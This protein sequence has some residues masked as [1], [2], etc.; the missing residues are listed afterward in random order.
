M[1]HRGRLNV[2]VNVLGKSPSV[3]F[4][5]FEGKYDTA[6]MQGSGD[7]KYHKGFSSD[8]RT[9]GGNVH[10]A[11]A[12][13]PS[14]LEVVNPVVEGS[15][16]ARQERRGDATGTRVLPILIHGDAAFAGQGVVMETLQLSQ[17]R[18][19]FTGGSIHIIVNNQVG[20][21]TSDPRDARS[22]MYCSDVAKMLETP[23]FHVNARRSGSGGVRHAARA[24]VSPAF[25][26]GRG[27]RSRLL[28]PPWPQRGG[29]AIGHAADDVPGHPQASDHAQDLRRQARRAGRDHRRR[30]RGDDRVV[31]PGS[32]RGPPAGAR[33]ARHDRQQVHG[34]LEQVPR[35]RLDRAREGRR[36]HGAAQGARCAHREFPGEFRAASARRAGHGQSREDARRRIAARLGLRRDAGVRQHSRRRQLHPLHGPG[37]RSRHVLPSPRGAARSGHGQALRPAAAHRRAPAVVPDHRLGAV[38]RSRARFRIRLLDHRSVGA[39]HL[40]RS[41]RRLRER[42]AGHHRPVHQLG[43]SEVGPPLRTHA[44]PAARLRRPGP[45]AFLRAP[46]A[47]PATLRREQHAGVRAFDARADVSHDPPADPAL[48]C[49]SRSS[50]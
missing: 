26:Q 49:A 46:R 25:P 36:R 40:G 23:I 11:L 32:R 33:L 18:A 30:C 8:L 28:S 13:N 27:H 24:R 22:T 43:R 1:A 3:L 47:L 37:R 45:G 7:V 44:V 15:V 29:R 14:H 9:P 6:H 19:F 41:V 20:F 35:Q 16:R 4:N 2:L 39:R 12:F 34:R 17:A 10:V 50:S 5:E 48:A 38:R 31:S 42:R 21:T